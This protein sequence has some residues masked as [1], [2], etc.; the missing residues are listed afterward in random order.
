MKKH[1]LKHALTGL[2][3]AAAF[4]LMAVSCG[5]AGDSAGS[6]AGTTALT[7]LKTITGSIEPQT[8]DL[9]ELENYIV[10]LVE[11][12]T[13]IVQFDSDD[14]ISAK[15][16]FQL[17]SVR[18]SEIQTAFELSPDYIFL[19]SHLT[20]SKNGATSAKNFAYFKLNSTTMPLLRDDRPYLRFLNAAADA[21]SEI[22]FDTSFATTTSAVDED[23]TQVVASRLTF[24]PNTDKGGIPSVFDIDDDN[25]DSDD[26]FPTSAKESKSTGDIATF[27]E[28]IEYFNVR[29]DVLPS[30]SG[31][32]PAT[33]AYL[34]HF[35][36]KMREGVFPTSVKINGADSLL[37]NSTVVKYTDGEPVTGGSSFSKRELKDDGLSEDGAE[38]DN[39]Y[40]RRVVI[41]ESDTVAP[42]QKHQVV[43][44]Q[45]TFGSGSSA[46]TMSFPYTFA[47]APS[48][49]DLA[50]MDASVSITDD[51]DT[52]CADTTTA[53][54]TKVKVSVTPFAPEE[55][56][57]YAVY[58]YLSVF[59]ATSGARLYL[60]SAQAL[61]ADAEASFTLPL[62]LEASTEYQYRVSIQTKGRTKDFPA[63]VVQSAKK[64][65]TTAA[66]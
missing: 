55:T 35:T 34:L 20:N 66:R 15:G 32:D 17:E 47:L 41:V 60:S 5:Q 40:G 23:A 25:D 24:D 39:V 18:T 43:F 56:D 63:Y 36:T 51:T 38:G 9:S 29:V 45:V 14:G 27:P 59:D 49:I 4:G 8:G 1:S 28:I 37:K 12:E 48:E 26:I 46:T 10:G 54:A 16:V 44:L 19:A 11:K 62:T 61:A 42:P 31:D 2:S 58:C 53:C 7:G 57:N 33:P 50:A 22:S 65:L 64:S 6:S 3:L 52:A 30:L 13:G 21:P